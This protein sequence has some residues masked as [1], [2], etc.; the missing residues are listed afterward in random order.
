MRF[1]ATQKVL[2]ALVDTAAVALPTKDLIP[3]L[4]SMHFIAT[5]DRLEVIA[6]DSVLYVDASSGQVTIE[7]PGEAIFPG[8]T[9]KEMVSTIGGGDVITVEAGVDSG[10]IEAGRTKWQVSLADLS[11]YPPVP[12]TKDVMWQVVSG[13]QLLYG[14]EMVEYAISKDSV[15]ANLRMVHVADGQMYAADASQFVRVPFEGP[16]MDVPAAAIKDLKKMLKRAGNDDVSVGVSDHHLIFSIDADTFWVARTT[17][18]FPDVAK[19]LSGPETIN[20]ETVHVSCDDLLSAVRRVRILADPQTSAVGLVLDDDVCVVRAKDKFGSMAVEEIAVGW[21]H[22]RR[23]V[24]FN[25]V[26]LTNLLKT[27]PDSDIEIRFGP[28]T[29]TSPSVGLVSVDGF[30]AVVTQIRTDLLA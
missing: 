9:F 5:D 20:N 10:T 23:P 13:S 4:K 16:D 22:P 28:D 24:A 18:T 30:T 2:A 25:H 1:L 6:T 3:V 8:A 14:L 15:R 12:A 21:D 7:E 29:K 26:H 11:A 17:S 19:T 27:Y